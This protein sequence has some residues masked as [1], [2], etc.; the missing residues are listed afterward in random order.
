MQRQ[1]GQIELH[2]GDILFDQCTQQLI[3]LL[4]T[5]NDLHAVCLDN[6]GNIHLCLQMQI[7][8]SEGFLDIIQISGKYHL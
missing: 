4:I 5:G 7:D 3:C 6:V 1:L 2:Y 8:P